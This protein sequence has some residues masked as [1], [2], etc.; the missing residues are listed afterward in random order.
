M[1]KNEFFAAANIIKRANQVIKESQ[2][3]AVTD[4]SIELLEHASAK[5]QHYLAKYGTVIKKRSVYMQ[6]I[7]FADVDITEEDM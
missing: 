7:T 1:T 5:M 4:D 6:E 2:L 3:G